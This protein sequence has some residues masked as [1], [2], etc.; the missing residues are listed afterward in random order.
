M[1]EYV[2]HEEEI[3]PPKGSG[4][5]GLLKAIQEIVQ[6]GRVQE[7][8]VKTNGK[9]E[10]DF[11]LRKN[12]KKQELNV[13]FEKVMPYAIVRNTDLQE[14]PYPSAHAATALAEL[15]N[16]S[17][18]EHLF[19]IAFLGSDNTGFWPWYEDTTGLTPITKE[20]LFGLP[21]LS[22]PMMPE[23]ALLLC[24]GFK[25]NGVITDTVKSFKITIPKVTR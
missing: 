14:I 23:M 1:S 16:A 11:Y 24:T 13:Q 5:P 7:I 6:I 8:R 15:F 3:T 21:F 4:I 10:Y 17:G 19:P 12:E 25:R 18:K 20:E 9:I 22:D 2:L